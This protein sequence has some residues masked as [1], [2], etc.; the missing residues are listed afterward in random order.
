[1]GRYRCANLACGWQGLLPRQPLRQMLRQATRASPGVMRQL[2]AL[3]L[4]WARIG[5]VLLVMLLLVLVAVQGA[6]HMLGAQP[7]QVGVVVPAGESHDGD[8]L[9]SRHP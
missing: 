1:M 4:P 6:R 7:A 5:S 9:P 2:A 8:A 3:D